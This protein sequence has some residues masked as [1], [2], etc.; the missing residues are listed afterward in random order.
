MITL[1]NR[2]STKP[3][4]VNKNL[5]AYGHPK[6]WIFERE[7]AY[8]N[9]LRELK[10]DIL[11][12][13][14]FWMPLSFWPINTH[15]GPIGTSNRIHYLQDVEMSCLVS[16]TL[17]FPDKPLLRKAKMQNDLMYLHSTELEDSVHQHSSCDYQNLTE[18]KKWAKIAIGIAG[19]SI[20]GSNHWV[21][22]HINF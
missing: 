11:C 19:W 13:I 12:S 14:C 4:S 2:L 3:I 16:D 1:I 5:E 21:I 17:K 9:I 18:V 20:W 8:R 22:Q 6:V 15:H 10:S 7:N